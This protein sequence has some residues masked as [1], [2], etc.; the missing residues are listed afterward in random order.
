MD[1][2]LKITWTYLDITGSI[3]SVKKPFIA[4]DSSLKIS[5]TDIY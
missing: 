1:L 2:A 3:K 5:A 4:I